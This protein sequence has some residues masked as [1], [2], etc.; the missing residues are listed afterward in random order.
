MRFLDER[1]K[2]TWKVKHEFYTLT[3]FQVGRRVKIFQEFLVMA[4]GARMDVDEKTPL[5]DQLT[6]DQLFDTF[7]RKIYSVVRNGQTLHV[8]YN[9]D[10]GNLQFLGTVSYDP[11]DTK[12]ILAEGAARLRTKDFLYMNNAKVP[13]SGP[14]INPQSASTAQPTPQNLNSGRGPVLAQ[15][16]NNLSNAAIVRASVIDVSDT[17][18]KNSGAPTGDA[19]PYTLSGDAPNLEEVGNMILPTTQMMMDIANADIQKVSDTTS[20]SGGSYENSLQYLQAITSRKRIVDRIQKYIAYLSRVKATIQSLISDIQ[21][22]RRGLTI[23]TKIDVSDIPL[24]TKAMKKFSKD[25]F[26]INQMV[27]DVYNMVNKLNVAFQS[28]LSGVYYFPDFGNSLPNPPA[29]FTIPAGMNSSSTGLQV[30]QS[31]VDELNK[32]STE[33][34]AATIENVRLL[35]ANIQNQTNP[36]QTTSTVLDASVYITMSIDVLESLLRGY[37]GQL[38][39]MKLAGY[40]AG[41]AILENDND[42]A[43]LRQKLGRDLEN[44]IDTITRLINQKKQTNGQVGGTPQ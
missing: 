8:V 7:G 2:C 39:I 9:N 40:R 22:S 17:L 32:L 24:Y 19:A 11:R 38:E 30:D 34:F 42:V 3:F 29:Q 44:S 26:K 13:Q 21:S 31:V 23:P 5:L 41:G 1:C 37:T 20:L 25:R 10:Q 12:E 18:K 35:G 16:G 6:R 36:L 27:N 28:Q 43:R 14:P 33:R 4:D 15:A